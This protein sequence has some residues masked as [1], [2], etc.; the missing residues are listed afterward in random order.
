MGISCCNHSDGSQTIKAPDIKAPLADETITT[1]IKTH[2]PS[3]PLACS[4][5]F[6]SDFCLVTI[7]KLI[8]RL[9]CVDLP[10]QSCISGPTII[11]SRFC[12][13]QPNSSSH[14]KH[15]HVSKRVLVAMETRCMYFRRN[16]P[17]GTFDR[18]AVSR[19]PVQKA[20]P[21]PMYQKPVQYSPAEI[22]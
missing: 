20:S 13:V 3:K 15:N 8:G 6:S 22:Y 14:Q 17:A 18:Q 11:Y 16:S 2:P 9:N 7:C 21:S 19:N 10:L 12:A 1:V 5:A 4:F